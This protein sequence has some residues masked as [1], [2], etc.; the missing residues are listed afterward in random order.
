MKAV[1]QNVSS[2]LIAPLIR[3]VLEI[4]AWILVQ[5]PVDKTQFAKSLTIYRLVHVHQGTQEIRLD[6]AAS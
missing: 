1:G 2:I 6:S 4:S 3:L 5:E